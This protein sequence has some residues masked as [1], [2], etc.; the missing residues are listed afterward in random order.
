[1]YN[2]VDYQRSSGQFFHD[3]QNF[4]QRFE[5]YCLGVEMSRATEFKFYRSSPISKLM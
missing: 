2:S 5:I 1:M 4:D 3:P